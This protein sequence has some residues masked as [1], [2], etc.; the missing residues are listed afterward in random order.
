MNITGQTITEALDRYLSDEAHSDL[1]ASLIAAAHS[2]DPRGQILE[3]LGVKGHLWPEYCLRDQ[4]ADD[5]R[6]IA[7]AV[8]KELQ[9]AEVAA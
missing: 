6:M 8:V 1:V 5:R 2:D 4:E 3:V 9:R 7:R